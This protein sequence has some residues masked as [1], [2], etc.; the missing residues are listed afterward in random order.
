MAEEVGEERQ[1]SHADS[2]NIDMSSSGIHSDDM[3]KWLAFEEEV[4]YA[5]NISYT[6]A[7]EMQFM[8]LDTNSILEDQGV[9]G[10]FSFGSN[11]YDSGML[12]IESSYM[13]HGDGN[14]TLGVDIAEMDI[15]GGENLLYKEIDLASD[16][17]W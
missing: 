9:W 12:D 13:V 2:L 1:Y 6:K 7:A 11:W 5:P 17:A 3:A 16:F 4:I 15:E 10:Q 8:G 14:D